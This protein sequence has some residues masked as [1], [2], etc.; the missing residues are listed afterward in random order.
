M[1][2]VTE[3]SGSRS[4]PMTTRKESPILAQISPVI[5]ARSLLSGRLLGTNALS[6][7]VT[8]A[9]PLV[10]AA[11]AI[12]M[13][14][15]KLGADKFGLLSLSWI[16]VGYLSLFDMGIG[17]ALTKLTAERIGA[18]ALHEIPTL[19][20][21]CVTLMA[22]F[23]AAVTVATI[24][25]A[26]WLTTNALNVPSALQGEFFNSLYI[27]SFAAPLVI[28]TAGLRGVLEAHQELR[29]ANLTR[30]AMGIGTYIGPVLV[31]PFTHSLT[32]IVAFLVALR[33]VALMPHISA[34]YTVVPALRSGYSFDR[35]LIKPLY[36][37]GFW[38]TCNSMIGQFMISFDRFYIA[39]AISPSAVSYYSVPSELTSRI[40]I[41]S[42]AAC[43][44]LFPA[45]ATSATADP[46]TCRALFQSATKVLCLVLFALSLVLTVFS[47]E[48]LAV[49][50]GP[51]FAAQS[52]L[53]A[54]ILPIGAFALGLEAVSYVYLQGIGRP[55][56]PTIVNFLEIPLYYIALKFLVSQYGLKGAALASAGRLVIDFAC[57]FGL[58]CFYLKLRPTDTIKLTSGIVSLGLLLV[59]GLVP[60]ALPMKI[61]MFVILT[62]IGLAGAWSFVLDPNDR[63]F[64]VR[65]GAPYWQRI[66]RMARS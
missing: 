1:N 41:V 38:I 8:Q 7:V 4:C 13:L 44:V 65:F 24:Y 22:V 42:S 5:A 62:S 33:L 57:L 63:V 55:E 27:L 31:L 11:V 14:I 47:P 23:G 32:A 35:R 51:A 46:D 16:V 37:F 18:G 49:W 26:R 15:A 17:R 45:F 48:I 20:W 52:H 34:C 6:N 3:G 40:W 21:T 28:V 58:S 59:I 9:T 29:T 60:L 43:G 39:S 54:Q 2:C 19:I 50:L 25:V 30:F 61:V 66:A 10:A 12:P 53:V 56:L 64:I 36:K